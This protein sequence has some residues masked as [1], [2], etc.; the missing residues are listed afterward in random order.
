M[1]CEFGEKIREVRKRRHMTML[2]VAEKAGLSESLISQIERNKVSPAIDTLL[3]IAEILEIDLEYLFYDLKKNKK[4]NLVRSDKRDKI[5]LDKV[6][7]EQLSKTV[8]ENTEHG[9]QAYEMHIEV[10]GK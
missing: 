5:V 10:G 7:Y 9:I 8:E 4:V 1:K 2:D 6:V 3:N